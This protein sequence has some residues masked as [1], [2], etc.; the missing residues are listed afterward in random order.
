ML[1]KLIYLES[2][3]L[4]PYSNSMFNSHQLGF[5]QFEFWVK[6]FIIHSEE[7]H[8]SFI[9]QKKINDSL[10]GLYSS[11]SDSHLYITPN[12]RF[13]VLD[14]D[15]K[16]R[17]YFK[18]L[19]SFTDYLKWTEAE[20]N[21]IGESQVCKKCEFFGT[22]LSEHLQFLQTDVHGCN[23]F[24]DLLLWARNQDLSSYRIRG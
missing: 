5:K 8:F 20:K 12:G 23:G 3:E 19:E 21:L 14:F 1:K 9:N 24:K 18:E 10:S 6:E 16:K 11:W 13:A 2:F 7:F 15:E 4:K 17:E 22:C